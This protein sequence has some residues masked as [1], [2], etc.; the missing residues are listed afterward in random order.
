MGSKLKSIITKFLIFIIFV[1]LTKNS[2][3][4]KIL[5]ESFA[6]T[7]FIPIL[8]GSSL[9]PQDT[10]KKESK[11]RKVSISGIFLSAGGGLSVPIAQFNSTSN[12]K[13][14]ILGR[15]EYSSTSIFPVVVGGEISYFSYTGSDN[16]KTKYFLTTF[17]TKIL[18]VGLTLDV[19]FSRLL[20]SYYTIPFIC[21]DLK[22]NSIKRDISGH[23]SLPDVPVKESK[24]SVGA[25]FGFTLFVMDFY[26]K[27]NYMKELSSIGVFTKIKFPVIRF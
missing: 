7:H 11:K 12:P 9:I 14:G 18:S 5:N 19:T 20:K 13:F 17:N 23:S 2:Y 3:S 27:Y 1:F 26:V 21:L 4:Q 8:S 22:T 24:I 25:G 6:N 15:I 16:Y 10:T